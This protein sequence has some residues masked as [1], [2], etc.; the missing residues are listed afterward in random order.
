MTLHRSHGEGIDLHLEQRWE[1]GPNHSFRPIVLR[2][3]QPPP[4]PT[5]LP[6]KILP[7]RPKQPGAR[8]SSRQHHHRSSIHHLPIDRHDY[9]QPFIATSR[10][11]RIASQ[12]VFRSSHRWQPAASV[13]V[14]IDADVGRLQPATRSPPDQPTNNGNPQLLVNEQSFLHLSNQYQRY[15]LFFDRYILISRLSLWCRYL[16]IL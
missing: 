1:N 8:S 15:Q 5:L 7:S 9:Q 13:C 12:R 16:G 11:P 10:S 14:D 3:Q 4:A 6:T 2:F